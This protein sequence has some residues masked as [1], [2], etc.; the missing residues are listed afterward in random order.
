MI[1]PRSR[2]DVFCLSSHLRTAYCV[3]LFFAAPV[4]R[5]HAAPPAAM[6][7]AGMDADMAIAVTAEI[8][9]QAPPRK[10]SPILVVAVIAVESSFRHDAV[11][12]A[13]AQGLMQLMP[14]TAASVAEWTGDA[15]VGDSFDPVVNVRLGIAYLAHLLDLYSGDTQ[16][17]L[18]AYHRGPANVTA[19]LRSHGS[20]PAHVL[21]A[22]AYRIAVAALALMSSAPI[23]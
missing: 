16:K 4:P 11:S 7:A 15:W 2:R 1:M 8:C 22:Y 3:A 17:A 21:E 14:R 10:I 13:G 12:S 9:R 23:C 18:T 20:L 5:A 19:I 6:L